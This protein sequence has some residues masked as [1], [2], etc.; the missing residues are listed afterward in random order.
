MGGGSTPRPMALPPPPPLPIDPSI[1]EARRR[2]RSRA[3]AAVGATRLT[4]P[5]GIIGRPGVTGPTLLG[6]G[7][8]RLGG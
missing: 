4:G 5:R 3:Q 2:L 8:A 7:S 1:M 6:G